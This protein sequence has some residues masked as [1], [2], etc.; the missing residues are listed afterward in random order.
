M[1][2]VSLNQPHYPYI[3][4]AEKFNYYL[5]RVTPFVEHKTFDHPFLS[6][7]QVRPEVDV[8]E[9]DLRRATAAYYGMIETIDDEYGRILDALQ[10]AGQDLDDWIIVYTSDHGEML[11]ERNL[12]QKKK[13]SKKI[14]CIRQTRK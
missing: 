1:L 2:K 5:N 10:F 3:A 7:R 9:R 12:I 11:G 13:L 6:Q 14:L 4:R 8:T